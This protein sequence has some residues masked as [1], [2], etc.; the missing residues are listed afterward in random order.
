MTY[1]NQPD[2]QAMAPAA[3][4]TAVTRNVVV[5]AVAGN[6]LEFYDFGTYAFF[7]VYIGKAFF[8][9]A[10]DFTSLLLSVAVFGVGF[11][12]R[13]LGGILIGAY[14]DRAGRKPAMM[15]TILLITL[16][17]LGLAL[18]P[19][20][21]SIGMA[22]PVLVVLCRLV[23][24]LALGGEVGPSTAFLIEIS[25][26][27]KRGF[28]ASWQF[29]SQGIAVLLAG[30]VGVLLSKLMAPADL[31][32]W[33]WRIPFAASLLLI[34]IAF[35]LRR[36][37]PETIAPREHHDVGAAPGLMRQLRQSARVIVLAVLVVLGGT[38][39]TYVCMYMTTYAINTLKFPPAT[40]LAA[41]V[42]LGVS[43]VTFSLLG[44]WLSDRFG[45]KPVMLIPRVLAVLLA[46]PAFMLLIETRT[47]TALIGVTVLLAGLTFISAAASL[48]T[49]PE[50]LPI[51]I[52]STGLS[53]A[54][55]VGVA[56]F[57]G[58]TQLVITWL[59]GVTGN[60]V[61]PAWY[62]VGTGIVS[63]LA[64]LALPETRGQELKA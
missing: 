2:P 8:P 39:P 51:R 11:V 62:L 23:Q 38:V 32:A 54:Y 7:A 59:I 10:S 57:G 25:P 31:Q 35:Y 28:Y 46:Y 21:E 49:I 52:R 19:S 36:R 17:T 12:T 24:G 20:Y 40:A 48:V 41:T 45:R 5:A 37:M 27:A 63:A 16:G 15:L 14:G 30:L 56:V 34:P 53:I 58:S 55:A 3:A 9:A 61:A 13:P 22:A 47:T 42:A 50:L 64:M 33:G 26:P 44:G 29:A 4:P 60:P 6:A 1:P 43:T 18:T